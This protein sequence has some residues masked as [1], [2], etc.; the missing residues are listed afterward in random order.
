MTSQGSAA[1]TCAPMT[2]PR[3]N[4]A[5]QA[6]AALSND[7]SEC[8]FTAKQ[9]PLTAPHALV[10]AQRCLFCVDAPCMKAC[11]THIDVPGFIRRIAHEQPGLAA[12]KIWSANILGLS[13]S[14]ACPVEVLC[15]GACVLNH[16]DRPPIRIGALQH[17]ALTTT[18]EERGF[19]LRAGS[20]PSPVNV[21]VIG[22]GP[23]GVAVAAELRLLGHRVTVFEARD[24]PGGLNTYGIAPYKLSAKE[25]LEEVA[26]LEQLG[27]E[28]R[29][30]TRVGADGV[31]VE[32]LKRDYQAIVLACGIGADRLLDVP[33][34]DREGSVGATA[35]VEQMKLGQVDVKKVQHALVLGGGN[36]ALDLVQELKGLGVPR[37]T[38]AIRRT[39]AELSGYLHEWQHAKAL[40]VQLLERVQPIGVLGQSRVSGVSFKVAGTSDAIEVDAEL[41]VWAIGQDKQFSLAQELGVSI[42]DGHVVCDGEQR[43]G[44]NVWVVGDAANGGKE[45]V[46]A[47]A[48]AK[49]AA[50]SIDATLA[51]RTQSKRRQ[52][53]SHG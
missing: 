31:P 25:A 21:A 24:Y 44:N 4:A 27:A 46:N 33:G 2:N 5:A 13:C 8:T 22:A 6:L 15:E 10:E 23:G 43:A 38:M 42:K 49:V 45:V 30:G 14:T 39:E 12:K 51:S 50:A 1:T 11:P 34:V 48:E 19:P 52:E 20:H 37:V 36:T 26:W 3:T 32:Q 16:E 47:A 7:R 40:G 29:C 28:L 35:F 17:F 41:V 9:Q 53:I 18:L